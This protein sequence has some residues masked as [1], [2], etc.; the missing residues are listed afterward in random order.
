MDR[1]CQSSGNLTDFTT[2]GSC[3]Q[4]LLPSAIPFQGG[5]RV[6]GDCDELGTYA[7]TPTLLVGACMTLPRATLHKCGWGNVQATTRF[8]YHVM[9]DLLGEAFDDW[10]VREREVVLMR[11]L[12]ASCL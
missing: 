12:F 7:A 6:Y 4:V 2:Y 8:M 3:S 10:Q 5:V 1:L 11:R 9:A